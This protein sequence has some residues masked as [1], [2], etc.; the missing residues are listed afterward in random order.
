ML[1]VRRF[2]SRLSWLFGLVVSIGIGLW[3][4]ERGLFGLE[5]QD[6]VRIC[7]TNFAGCPDATWFFVRFGAHQVTAVF[8]AA[9]DALKPHLQSLIA[10]GSS[11]FAVWK[12]W[13]YREAA[14]FRRLKERVEKEVVDL[15]VGRADLLDII[16]RPSPGQV[17]TVPLFAEDRLRTV[18]FKRHWR[19]VL[20][21]NDP[22]TTTDR[23]L[24]R[25]LT[26]IEKQLTWTKMRE[27]YY[28][29]Q[30]ATVHL[31]KGAI[32]S[33]R[34]E[35]A[36]SA[37]NWWRLNHDALAHFRSVLSEP[38][39]ENDIEATEY[40]GHQLRRLAALDNALASYEKMGR[41]AASIKEKLQRDLVVARAKRYQA[42]IR[43]LQKAYGV[44][45]RL[46][47]SA[48]KDLEAHV[49]LLG[50]HLL[51]RGQTN[52]LQGCVRLA[53][54]FADAAEDSFKAAEVDYQKLVDHYDP[55][56]QSRLGRTLARLR[57]IFHDDGTDQLFKEA[58]D[59]LDRVQAALQE[60]GQA[61]PVQAS[62]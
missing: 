50:R 20:S 5:A 62:G 31:I 3:V 48:L 12:W 51:E 55:Q 60:G 49:P 23:R 36:K 13:R 25:A 52:E 35:K 46:L 15:R 7:K 54:K 44:S 17:A 1:F 47:S 18:F 14:L 53:L 37:H 45:N 39:N 40:S 43:R 4:A 16:C 30:R 57:R 11:S 22:V 41:L 61:T 6:W 32:A 34:S 33:A 29:E 59:G 9:V 56:K 38:D 10:L 42:E 19:W 8:N 2:V 28:R 27:T 26:E 24:D 21:S 58:K